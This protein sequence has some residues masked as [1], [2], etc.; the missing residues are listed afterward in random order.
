MLRVDS[1]CT[2]NEGKWIDHLVL[3]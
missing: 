2:V 1:G 3:Q